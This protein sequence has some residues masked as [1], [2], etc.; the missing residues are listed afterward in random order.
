[1]I[2]AKIVGFTF[3]MV[4]LIFLNTIDANFV[5]YEKLPQKVTVFAA[6]I[7]MGSGEFPLCFDAISSEEKV[8]IMKKKPRWRS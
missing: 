6:D 7:Y 2:I 3:V 5:D 8:K 1:M 4:R